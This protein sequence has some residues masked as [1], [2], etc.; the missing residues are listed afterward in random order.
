VVVEAAE[1]AA[2]APLDAEEPL[3]SNKSI[4]SALF[5]V[6]MVVMFSRC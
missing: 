4:S 2:A 5:M 3:D 6:V 1:A